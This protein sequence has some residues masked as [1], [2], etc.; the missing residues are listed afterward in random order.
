MT[1]PIYMPIDVP[2]EYAALNLNSTGR[3]LYA[4]MVVNKVSSAGKKDLRLLC[5][6]DCVVLQLTKA[7][8]VKRVARLEDV[9]EVAVDTTK[10]WIN[11]SFTTDRDWMME[12][13]GHSTNQPKDLTD[14]I[15][16]LRHL[17]RNR[18]LTQLKVTKRGLVVSKPRLASRGKDSSR[19]RMEQL[20]ASG[21]QIPP[22]VRRTRAEEYAK[23]LRA[24]KRKITL[25]TPNEPW[26][27]EIIKTPD[28]RASISRSS[29]A[30][31]RAGVLPGII[32]QINGQRV[33]HHTA[34]KLLK[35][36]VAEKEKEMTLH[37]V[38]NPV[39]ELNDAKQRSEREHDEQ[40]QRLEDELIEKATE[41]EQ[42][43]HTMQAAEADTQAD[44][45]AERT[46]SAASQALGEALKDEIL[47]LKT[48]VR[49]LKQE[50]EE[51]RLRVQEKLADPAS[52]GVTVLPDHVV[53]EF[54]ATTAASPP[55]SVNQPG[56][57]H[58]ALSRIRRG[59]FSP[60]QHHSEEIKRRLK[61]QAKKTENLQLELQRMRVLTLSREAPPPPLEAPPL[62]IDD[63]PPPIE[64]RDPRTSPSPLGS[65]SVMFTPRDE[66]T[67]QVIMT[68][69]MTPKQDSP[70]A[71]KGVLS[72]GKGGGSLPRQE[73]SLRDWYSGRLGMDEDDGGGGGGGGG[74]GSVSP[75]RGA[76]PKRTYLVPTSPVASLPGRSIRVRA[77]A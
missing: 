70:G 36:A 73:N 41:V 4:L 37:I 38:P 2:A 5:V 59:D 26:G 29:D 7:A 63:S 56:G 62:P 10:N 54:R 74:G 50:A 14:F 31:Q 65:P 13:T 35:S 15:E 25:K 16:L 3:P 22:D 11:L 55:K 17:R 27:L 49:D 33:D 60:E 1:Q 58:D 32:C 48:E 6:N 8:K 52:F 21:M 18:S 20:G 77:Q 45:R 53:R 57:V 76:D 66:R 61:D 43:K 42:L 71:I 39:A 30:A 44:L 67:S 72:A 19:H 69:L 40:R 23:E 64:L 9:S 51:E 28:G 46:K 75:L 68:P 47:D 12:R 34:T 24:V